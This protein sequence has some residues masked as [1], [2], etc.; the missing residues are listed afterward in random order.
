MP[1]SSNSRRPK[2]AT[3]MHLFRQSKT[4]GLVLV[5]TGLTACSEPVV[6]SEPP[7]RP[8]KTI[9]V[10]PAA[11]GEKLVQ[12]GEIRPSEETS[13]GFRIDGRIVSRLVDVLVP[14]SKRAMLSLN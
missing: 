12:T 3:L 1:K 9:V 14:S 5:F 10:D 13:L 8:V 7:I 2:E 11:G 6:E 4:C